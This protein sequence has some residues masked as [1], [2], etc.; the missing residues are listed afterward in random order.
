M[1]SAHHKLR[2]A[3]LSAIVV[4]T[5]LVV[6]ACGQDTDSVSPTPTPSQEPTPVQER[7][8]APLWVYWLQEPDLVEL[9]RSDADIFVIDYSHDGTEEG[10]FTPADLQ[11]LQTNGAGTRTVLA[12]MS[13]GEAEDY[14]FYWQE[15]WKQGNPSWLDEVNPHWAGNFKVRYWDQGWQR[16]IFGSPMSY[17]DKLLEAGFDG[18]YLDIIDTYAHYADQG[19]Q[20][21]ESEMVEFVRALSAYAKGKDPDFLIIPQ[22]A[23]ELGTHA[24]Y[25]EAVDGV[26]QEGLHYGYDNEDEATD[27]SVTSEIDAYLKRF[28]DA[29]KL[30]LVVDYTSSP[31]NVRDAY[32][33][34][35]AKGYYST[36]TTVDLDSLPFPIDSSSP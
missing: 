16:V 6:T 13:I 30:V 19:R 7:E 31:E 28:L 25:L 2:R 34:S 26:A 32:P 20:S 27:P 11:T 15:G 12:Y 36:V 9:S 17:V 10:V 22:N 8:D 24:S 35:G 29:G 23:P 14:R 18:A 21:A 3:L 1:I 5:T 4:G 33:L